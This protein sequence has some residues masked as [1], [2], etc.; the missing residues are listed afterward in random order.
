MSLRIGVLSVLFL[1][2]SAFGHGFKLDGEY[3]GHGTWKSIDGSRGK[4]EMSA[5]VTSDKDGVTSKESVVIHLPD[6]TEKKIEEEWTA[7]NEK[8]GFFEVHV[9]G[10]KVGSGYCRIKQCHLQTEDKGDASEETNTFHNGHIYR[11]GSHTS[12]DKTIA[13]Q[14]VMTKKRAPK[15]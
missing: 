3:V 8:N 10:V 11:I 12:K 7:T 1:G 4:F 13:W 2:A 15:K 14:G 5:T 6:G 9:K